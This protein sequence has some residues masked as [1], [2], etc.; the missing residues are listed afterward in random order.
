MMDGS[1]ESSIIQESD[2]QLRVLPG[3]RI[4]MNMLL[5]MSSSFKGDPHMCPKC[6][7]ENQ[8]AKPTQGIL[9]WYISLPSNSRLI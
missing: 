9:R 3:G 4:A 6:G 1:E 8:R 2:W 7:T 5:R